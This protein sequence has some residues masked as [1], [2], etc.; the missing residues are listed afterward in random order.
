MVTLGT[1]LKDSYLLIEKIDAVV[2]LSDLIG[3]D[4][5]WILT[6][7][8]TPADEKLCIEFRDR[9][10][11]RLNGEPVAYI[12][13]KKEFYSLEFEVTCDVLIPRPETEILA[14]WAIENTRD[15][16]KVLD[17]CSG[18]GCLGI[19]LACHRKCNVTMLDVSKAAINVAKRNAQKHG[20]EV[21]FL[22]ND[23]LSDPIFGE[24][25]VIV[26][27]PPYVETPL[28]VSLSR[29]VKYYEPALALDGGDDG[30]M[31]YPPIIEK[32]YKALD[33]KGYL[34]LEVGYNQASKVAE[35]MERNKF[36]QI[37]ILKDYS[38]IDRVVTGYKP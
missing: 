11:R 6:H 32:A 14:E 7:R 28:L 17:I 35:M 18:S 31:F 20:V 19:T 16:Y 15:Q 10:K 24:F 29:D 26:S 9:I 33:Y 37:K 4:K 5:A 27:N 38:G 21:S 1:L 36:T 3:K 23:I 22:N 13:G 8:S 12:T 25:D 2:L 34:G 30:L